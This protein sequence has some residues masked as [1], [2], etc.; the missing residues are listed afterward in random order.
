MG[1]VTE[2]AIT[3]DAN[4]KIRDVK[5]Y[6]DKN[7]DIDGVV[8]QSAGVPKG[9][10]MRYQLDRQVASL[11]SMALHYGTI[12]KIM[13]KEPLIVDDN[14]SIDTVSQIAINRDKMKLYNYIIVMSGQEMKGVVS[15]QKILD[16][17]TKVR[18]E[19]AKGANPLTGLPG[20]PAFERELIQ[21][22][23]N[24]RMFSFIFI[25]LD[26]FKSYNDKYGFERG[27]KV[28]LFTADL[29]RSVLRKYGSWDDFLGHIG[30]DDFYLF[31]EREKADEISRRIVRYY[32]RL[33]KSYYDEEDQKAGGIIGVDR[34]GIE[35][36]FPFIS[37]SLAIVDIEAGESFDMK[38]MLERVVHLKRYAKSLPGSVHVRDR[39]SN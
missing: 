13:D 29:L 1:E 10:V 20:N 15:I 33:I 35:R 31:T 37:I 34:D 3:V 21:R 9:L 11:S 19:M 25:D 22:R 16:A 24:G 18:L 4:M 39:R 32:D 28:L 38:K 17:L 23:S 2:P 5:T 36:T 27:D 8:V 12:E 26:H 7:P 14:M 6:F 30:G